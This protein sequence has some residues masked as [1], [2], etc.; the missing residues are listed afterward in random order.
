MKEA[1]SGRYRIVQSDEGQTAE[2]GSQGEDAKER[3]FSMTRDLNTLARDPQNT[4]Q[5]QTWKWFEWP[6]EPGKTWTFHYNSGT[7]MFDWTVK[8]VGWESVSVPAG[9]FKAVRLSL[10]RS[11]GQAAA[12]EEAW[13][14]PEAKAIVKRT[15]NYPSGVRR[16]AFDQ[17]T[18]ELVAYKLN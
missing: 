3:G 16:N 15:M 1:A 17:T 18:V 9:T 2:K 10:T 6:L 8:V 12:S 7:A 5:T 13:Y 11:G 4:G 14:A